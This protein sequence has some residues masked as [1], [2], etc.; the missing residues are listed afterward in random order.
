MFVT[1]EGPEGAG[2]ST[3]VK[4]V[5]EALRKEGH[6]VLATREPGDGPVGALIRE[7]LLHGR[8]LDPK[9]ELMLFLA[10]RAQHVAEAIR[11]ALARGDVVLCDR[12]AD[13]TVVYQGHARGL[14][15]ESLRAW[16]AFVTGGLQPDLTVLLDLAPEVGL[17]RIRAKDRLDAEPLDF[18][19]KVRNGFLAEA[20]RE[21]RRWAI[22]NASR[23]VGEVTAEALEAIKARL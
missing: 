7:V 6:S 9:A 22:V 19:R 8:D 1:F 18:H 12:Y 4:A 17:D 14:D 21:T 13:S 3:V 20:R 16:N 23:T 2:K 5:A 15:L 10:D 11:P